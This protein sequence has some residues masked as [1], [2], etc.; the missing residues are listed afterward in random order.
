[1]TVFP[2]WTPELVKPLLEQLDI[3]PASS[4]HRRDVFNHVLADPRMEA[5]YDEFLR[6]DRKL[7]T[8]LH[9]ARE[10]PEGQTADEA[11]LSAIRQALQL[12]VSAAGDRISVSKL[13]EIEK[14]KEKW[15]DHAERLRSLAHDMELAFQL[16]ALG[17]DDPTFP[18]LALH[19]AQALRRVANWIEHLTS[20]LRR[21]GDPLIVDR[22][23]GDPIVR[24]VQIMIGV[25]L[26]E[27]F[28]DRLDGTAATL[29][30]VVL[31]AETTPRASRSALTGQKPPIKR[32]AP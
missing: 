3:N 24:G 14:A 28:G 10:I 17:L 27:Q 23:R 5:V 25:K 16:G 31:G 11:Q 22:H 4:G 18:G 21:S 30:S 32:S 13:D 8:Y 26:E 2:D 6:R 12:A 9:P 20:A 29:T 19:D 1:M 7:G 15:K